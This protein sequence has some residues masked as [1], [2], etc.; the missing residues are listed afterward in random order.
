MNSTYQTSFYQSGSNMNNLQTSGYAFPQAI[1]TTD[2]VLKVGSVGRVLEWGTGGG[3]G[4]GATGA[5]G[6]TGSTGSTGATGV[7]II[8]TENLIIPVGICPSITTAQTN[9]IIDEGG[10]THS[11]T[12]GI[13]NINI[14]TDNFKYLNNETQNVSIGDRSYD[15]ALLQN[16]SYTTSVGNYNFRSQVGGN[17]NSSLGHHIGS[18][19]PSG[20][21]DLTNASY[22]TF[23]GAYAGST[24]A[25]CAERIAIGWDAVSNADYNASIG[26]SLMTTLTPCSSGLCSLGTSARKFKEVVLPNGVVNGSGTELIKGT[27]NIV[28]PNTIAP[29]LTG[30]SNI[31]IDQTSASKASWVGAINNISIGNNAMNAN[32]SNNNCIAI[33]PDTF[34]TT[35]ASSNGCVAIGVNAL[36]DH[37]TG[38]SNVGLGLQAGVYLSVASS[39]NNLFLGS[40]TGVTNGT[41]GTVDITGANTSTFIGIAS[42][43]NLATG[44]INRTHIGSTGYN[45][46]NNSVSLGH[47]ASGT[48]NIVSAGT[49]GLTD[50]GSTTRKFKSCWLE[51]GLKMK[52]AVATSRVGQLSCVYTSTVSAV[53]AFTTLLTNTSITANTIVYAT[54]VCP[55]NTFV[56]V[57]TEKTRVN[58]VSITFNLCGIQASSNATVIINYFLI[59]PY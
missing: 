31:I 25:T 41:Y 1:G 4:G 8:A 34:K 47:Y 48:E 24:D 40:N 50:L 22:C 2:Q 10:G 57:V 46:Q 44:N 11:L 58:G 18:N 56:Y 5:T 38:S 9:I 20:A 15:N 43:S 27:N 53:E 21:V 26:S 3:G 7:V 6:A 16:V 55:N 14:G 23:L 59:E 45:D 54:A 39:A 19:G 37:T 52:S 13:N 12:T 33:G 51:S 30:S 42:G 28:L 32:I 35:Q 17:Y 29:N 49:S 36:R